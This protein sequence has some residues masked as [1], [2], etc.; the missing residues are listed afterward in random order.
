VRSSLFVSLR[1]AAAGA[2]LAAA[3]AAARPVAAQDGPEPDD[4]PRVRREVSV[5]ASR[6]D[7]AP[8]TA[9]VR[10]VSREE[11]DALPGAHTVP[12]VLRSILGVDVRRRGPGGVQADVGI[13]GGDFNGTLVLV[14][15][16]PANDPQS[17]HLSF[18][19]DVPVAAIERIEVLA[20]PGSAVWGSNPIGG[21]VN[22]VTRA[23]ALGRAAVQLEGRY[24]H[25]TQSLDQGGARL[26]VRV[27]EPVTIGV[28]W[29]RAEAS[30]FR[31]DTEAASEIL[32]LSSRWDTGK[33]P[34][35][36]GL[37][38]AERRF[39]AYAFYGTAF[40]NQQESTRTR[41][42][43]LGGSLALGGFT[44]TPSVS[45]RAHHDDFVL[46]RGNPSFYENL[47]DT[48]TSTARV[49]VSH[50]A[51]GGSVAAGVEGG[52]DA[53]ASSNLGEHA[54]NRGAVFAEFARA[55]DVAA[56]GS[57]GFRLGL[58]ADSYEDYGSR[59][60]PYAGVTVRVAP[61]LTLRASFGTSFR[62]PTFTE[63]FYRDPQS[64]GNPGL[65]PETAWSVDAGVKLAAGPL[66]LDA[67][68]FHRDATNLID[69]VRT[70]GDPVFHA[71]NVLSAVTDGIEVSAAWE[72]GRPAFLSTLSVQAAWIFSDL[73]ALSASAG[74]AAEGRYVLDPLHV[75]TDAVV[76][77]ALPASLGLTARLTYFSRPSFAD[78][79]WLLSS[80]LSWQAFQGRILELFLEGENLGNVRYED[81]P[82]VPLPGR[83]ALA[84]FNLTW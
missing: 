47:S 79:V 80:R 25:G 41:T 17:N 56:P 59:V 29:W 69:F 46:D 37:G 49:S 75:K 10:V 32:R 64:A 11:I 58:R 44:L 82:G 70:P 2:G 61:P 35:T 27:A 66:G 24:A 1:A 7:D 30:G 50:A 23:G 19:L 38:I 67:G 68:Y 28:D 8:P 31:E 54:R 72:R 57:G 20:G 83:T 39:G 73:A 71:R 15:G 52:R 42:A 62:V 6:L 63:L 21:A 84:G 18:D 77:L 53:I 14:D 13:R 60:S 65:E 12:D 78:G 5:V 26:A 33:G 48:V 36:L 74:G 9:V 4:P 34:V 55:W 45:V 81:V 3:L 51:L 16:Q 43:A 22:I 76:G 40:P